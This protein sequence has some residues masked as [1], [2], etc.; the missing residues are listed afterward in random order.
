MHCPVCK[1]QETK[2]VDSRLA[3]DGMAIRRRRECVKC[4]YRFSTVEEME[5]LD[6]AI[7]KNDGRRESY[8]RSKLEHGIVQ[9]LAKRPYTQEAF[10]KLIYG[11]E[12]D[13]QKKKKRE[14]TSGEIGEIV[15]KHLK[16]FDKVAFIRF[17]SIYRAFEDV[18]TFEDEIK[19]LRSRRSKKS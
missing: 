17:A 12:R 5:L 18:T 15:M 16:K 14:V 2:V 6:I 4:N 19:L 1:S 3:Q 11:I 13:I 7:V 8:S 10:D 9:S